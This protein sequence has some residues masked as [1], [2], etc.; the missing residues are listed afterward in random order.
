[1]ATVSGGK[2][3]AEEAED[4]KQQQQQQVGVKKQDIFEFY[5]QLT[6]QKDPSFRLRS[7]Y[8]GLPHPKH[9]LHKSPESN[10]AAIPSGAAAAA[11]G[12]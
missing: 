10:A 1:V 9:K 7:A 5:A 2:E 6:S 12:G 11:G 4:G 3:A 8:A